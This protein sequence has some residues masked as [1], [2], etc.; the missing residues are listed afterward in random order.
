MLGLIFS[1][2]ESNQ[3]WPQRLQGLWAVFPLSLK[4]L[5]AADS[6]VNYC[7]P[8]SRINPALPQSP[9]WMLDPPHPF[10][11]RQD[12]HPKH[13]ALES[14]EKA[15]EGALLSPGYQGLTA[16]SFNQKLL[17]S[18]GKS[19]SSLSPVSINGQNWCLTEII[20][21]CFPFDCWAG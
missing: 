1:I 20:S 17:K 18:V 14:R 3:V 10:L 15:A 12:K 5:S 19:F 16:Q 7:F 4:S 11:S 8:Q 9:A 13:F 21:T 2:V 6:H